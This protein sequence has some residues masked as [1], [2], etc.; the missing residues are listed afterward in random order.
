MEDD[1]VDHQSD[2]NR[3]G[4]KNRWSWL[5]IGLSS[6]HFISILTDNL[7]DIAILISSTRVIRFLQ[8]LTYDGQTIFQF[9]GC[10]EDR[11][12]C[13]GSYN[14]VES[15]SSFALAYVIFIV[16][17]II[18]IYMDIM[19][20]QMILMQLLRPHFLQFKSFNRAVLMS[21]IQPILLEGIP[22]AC[23]A[24]IFIHLEQRPL[25]INC[26]ECALQN[27]PSLSSPSSV[28]TTTCSLHSLTLGNS[29]FLML[30]IITVGLQ[31]IYAFLYI[32]SVGFINKG[33]LPNGYFSCQGKTFANVS[34]VLFV[35][36]PISLFIMVIFGSPLAFTVLYF[37]LPVYDG[38]IFP[39]AINQFFYVHRILFYLA[40]PTTF[41][42]IAMMV[43][44]LPDK[45]PL[46]NFLVLFRCILYYL[47][48][49]L[50]PI[51]AFLSLFYQTAVYLAVLCGYGGRKYPKDE[52]DAKFEV[53]TLR[54]L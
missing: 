38:D 47:T 3:K 43:I 4:N 18:S 10:P 37:P 14:L 1:D 42:L 53:R 7:S 54:I 9:D 16:L 35:A 17:F 25:G 5:A 32:M 19:L 28:A 39:N 41:V 40:L 52:P 6:F 11:N 46:L 34:F 44:L 49:F 24:I 27:N 2:K 12:T 21:K 31:T 48:L 45:K 36:F 51:I 15:A 23:M 30:K 22:Q 50:V 13:C 33:R 29:Y 8:N 26:L 20:L